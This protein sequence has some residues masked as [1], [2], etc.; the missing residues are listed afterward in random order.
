M[1]HGIIMCDHGCTWHTWQRTGWCAAASLPARSRGSWQHDI[2]M[3]LSSEGFRCPLRTELASAQN[4]TE[5]RAID[6]VLQRVASDV[7]RCTAKYANI[8]IIADYNRLQPAAGSR[9]CWPAAA[10]APRPRSC[11]RWRPRCAH[12]C[13]ICD[14]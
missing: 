8:P 12:H 4:R 3:T 10:A 6:L 2:R 1:R 5:A 14:R 11:C 13:A 9:D 7:N